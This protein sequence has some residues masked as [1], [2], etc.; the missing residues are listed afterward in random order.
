MDIFN[1]IKINPNFLGKLTITNHYFIL[2]ILTRLKLTQQWYEI[3]SEEKLLYNFDFAFV[4]Q[5]FVL[6]PFI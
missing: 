5:I 4:I 2:T 3:I 6:N 1:L